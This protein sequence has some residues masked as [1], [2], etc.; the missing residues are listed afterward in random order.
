MRDGEVLDPLFA[1]HHRAREQAARSVAE[2]PA[3]LKMLEPAEQ[4][5]IVKVT[6]GL[7]QALESAAARS[8]V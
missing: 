2:L 5:Y 7:E 3:A 6:P 8:A 4:P 1:D